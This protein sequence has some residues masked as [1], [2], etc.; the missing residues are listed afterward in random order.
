MDIRTVPYIYRYLVSYCLSSKME[1]TL[2]QANIF[3][4]ESNSIIHGLFD[5]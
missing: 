1:Y 4:D 3:V 2:L 5:N